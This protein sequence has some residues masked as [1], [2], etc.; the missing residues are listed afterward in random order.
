MRFF[1]ILPSGKKF[2]LQYLA[3][4]I[5]RSTFHRRNSKILQTGNRKS[6][7]QISAKLRQA[8]SL[9]LAIRLVCIGI[10][11]LSVWHGNLSDIIL[12]STPTPN[13][14]VFFCRHWCSPGC[15]R[16]DRA[17]SHVSTHGLFTATASKNDFN[18]I[19]NLLKHQSYIGKNLVGGKF[20][21]QFKIQKLTFADSAATAAR[22]CVDAA[23]V[24]MTSR[25]R[26]QDVGGYVVP[27]LSS[28]SAAHETWMKWVW[29]NWNLKRELNVYYSFI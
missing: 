6:E 1:Y 29:V 12:P 28:S 17:I 15:M 14:L 26:R 21:R 16:L 8:N 25:V 5:E 27:S 10:Y 3:A 7:F 20:W 24:R 11:C 2:F 13:K 22:G 19:E 9:S 23:A 18:D 4:E